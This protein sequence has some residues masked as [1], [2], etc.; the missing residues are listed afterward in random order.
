LFFVYC[1]RDQQSR[2]NS[3]QLEPA[4]DLEK[5]KAKLP[6]INFADDEINPPQPRIL[7]REMPRVKN[8]NFMIV[9]A[10]EKTNGHLTAGRAEVPDTVVFAV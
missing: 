4:P 5:I 9:P 10:T 3:R 7:E 2:G 6:A 8:G 1:A